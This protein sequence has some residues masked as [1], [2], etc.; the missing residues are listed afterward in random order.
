M[1]VKN[2]LLLFVHG[3]GG[4]AK[5]TW[6]NFPN[7]ITSDKSLTDLV[8]IGFYQYPT[9]LFRLPFMKK[10]VKIQT[11]AN[12]LKTQ[13]E[14]RF[15]EYSTIILVCHSLGGLIARRY[16]I[17]EIK[18]GHKLKC[19]HLLL[20]AVPNN[21]AG[22]ASVTK[23]ITWKHDQLRQLCSSSDL[24]DDL[25]EDWFILHVPEQLNTKYIVAAQDRVVNSESAKSFW[26][27][28]DVETVVN[29]VIGI[30]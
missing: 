7:L 12:G 28:P 22:L 9:T 23:H 25:N 24:I 17:D 15:T 14:H 1:Q 2:S 13:I 11:L 30:L 19:R 29:R 27:N 18:R 10:A 3:L 6:G 21:G 4:N 20:F 26:G 8:D 5:D 16:L